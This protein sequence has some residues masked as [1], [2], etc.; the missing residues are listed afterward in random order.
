MDST[1]LERMD[2]KCF[3]I[4][5]VFVVSTSGSTVGG[6]FAGTASGRYGLVSGGHR[7]KATHYGA[8]V[9]GGS[10]NSAFGK[11]ALVAGGFT[12]KATG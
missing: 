10:L 1:S 8:T 3:V 4:T 9:G 2:E 7:G 6:G 12:S 11:Y 5:Q